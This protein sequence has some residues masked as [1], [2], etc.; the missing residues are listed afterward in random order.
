LTWKGNSRRVQQQVSV[1]LWLDISVICKRLS[2]SEQIRSIS[3]RFLPWVDKKILSFF[4]DV[5]MY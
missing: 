2:R 4:T 5:E 3:Q 1:F